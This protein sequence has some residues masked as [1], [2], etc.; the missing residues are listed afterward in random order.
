MLM[1]ILAGLTL[2]LA[3]VGFYGVLAYMVRQ[4]TQEIGIR[5]ALGA[6]REEVLRAVVL[7][8]TMLA[9]IG[10]CLGTVA[11]LLL[12]RTVS[13]LLYGLAANDPATFALSALLLI[14][15]ALVACYIPG[16]RAANVD[17]MVALRYE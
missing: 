6:R 9:F 13:S 4:R 10:V 5:M 2:M 11:G 17:P 14:S 16:R 15:V 3:A 7:R 1:G 8:G 12:S